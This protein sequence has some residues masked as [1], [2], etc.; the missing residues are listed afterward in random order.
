[1]NLT[2]IKNVAVL[3]HPSNPLFLKGGPKTTIVHWSQPTVTNT[4]AILKIIADKKV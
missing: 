2:Y 1:M 3:D 4:E